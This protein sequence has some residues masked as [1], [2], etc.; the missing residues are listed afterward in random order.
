MDLQ[1][2]VM[3]L[4]PGMQALEI[5][6]RIHRR[7]RSPKVIAGIIFLLLVVVAIGL[8]IPVFRI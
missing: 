6:P 8:I 5:A 7:S 3:S 1:G 4:K 2:C